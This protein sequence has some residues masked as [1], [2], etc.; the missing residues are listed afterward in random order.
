MRNLINE[1]PKVADAF[2]ALTAAIRESSVL[3]P[4]QNELTLIGIFTASRSLKGIHTHVER[5]IKHGATKEEIISCIFL[6]LPVCGIA[7][8]N[9]ALDEAMAAINTCIKSGE[10]S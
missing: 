1:V 5:A 8:V 4:K 2:F 10:V 9:M 6:A 3:E 7:S